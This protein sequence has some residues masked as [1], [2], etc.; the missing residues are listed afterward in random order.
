MPV[1]ALVIFL[2]HVK[3][4]R[5]GHGIATV[6]LHLHGNSFTFLFE[7]KYYITVHSFKPCVLC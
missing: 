4:K 2:S 7:L 1:Y 5:P 6:C 3:Q